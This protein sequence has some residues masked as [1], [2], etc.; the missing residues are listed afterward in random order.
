M[1]SGFIRQAPVGS[2]VDLVDKPKPSVGAKNHPGWS[3]WTFVP[4]RFSPL[5]T[6]LT[7]YVPLPPTSYHRVGKSPR[8]AQGDKVSTQIPP[9]CWGF[10]GSPCWAAPNHAPLVLL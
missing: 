8:K 9:C 5:S 6:T 7:H 3:Q 1:W 4:P 2:P 10:P